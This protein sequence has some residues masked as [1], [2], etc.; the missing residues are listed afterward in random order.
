MLYPRQLRGTP[1]PLHTLPT[2]LTGLQK[3]K[4]NKRAIESLAP[5]VK[6]IA[7]SLYMPVPEGDIR[8]ESRRKI[9]ER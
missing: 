6:A 3:T 4:A 9:L 7:D 5:R 8:E 2:T 1:F